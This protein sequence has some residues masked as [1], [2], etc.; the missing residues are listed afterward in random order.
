MQLV[1]LRAHA[2]GPPGAPFE[3]GNL[4]VSGD[5][6]TLVLGDNGVGKSTLIR[7]SQLVLGRSRQI[8]RIA[9]L[10]GLNRVGQVCTEWLDPGTGKRV[11]LGIALEKSGDE[12]RS[13]RY[14]IELLEGADVDEVAYLEASSL[15][16][17]RDQIVS[18]HP[19]ATWMQNS[20]S[21]HAEI[22]RWG[23]GRDS[24]LGLTGRDDPESPRQFGAEWI[25]GSSDLV[26]QIIRAVISPE[27]L[28]H[29]PVTELA[30]RSFDLLRMLQNRSMIETERHGR[31]RLLEFR[32]TR[33][34]RELIEQAA[35]DTPTQDR[36]S[37]THQRGR[38]VLEVIMRAVNGR[39]TARVFDTRQGSYRSLE[40]F[41]AQASS[42][43]R[44]FVFALLQF[45]VS[46][47]SADGP[48]RAVLFDHQSFF[49]PD[50]T[51]A[52][53]AIRK[54]GAS[55]VSFRAAAVFSPSP[56]FGSV[57]TLAR[58]PSAHA[59][60][61]TIIGSS[62]SLRDATPTSHNGEA[63]DT[64]IP[65]GDLFK[66]V[67]E[68]DL[69]GPDDIVMA[70]LRLAGT[71]GNAA[72]VGEAK[73]TGWITHTR[74]ALRAR[75]QL[76]AGELMYYVRYL[77]GDQLLGNHVPRGQMIIIRPGELTDVRVRKPD[78]DTL[79]AIR[80][81]SNA[82]TTFTT[83]RNEA[84]RAVDSYF[85][86]DNP[87]QSKADL[88]TAGRLTRQRR[89]AA[90]ALDVPGSKFRTTMPFPIAR[91]WRNVEA[92]R[93]DQ[94]GYSEVLECA[95]L[96]VTYCAAVGLAAALNQ[97]STFPGLSNFAGKIRQGN[98]LTFGVWSRLLEDLAGH[99]RSA[100][101]PPLSP[102]RH[103]VEFPSTAIAA[104]GEL[105]SR[106]NDIS[107]QRRPGPHEVGTHFNDA[108]RSLL[109]L[110]DCFYWLT[111]YPL[112]IVEGE[113]WDSLADETEVS[114]RELVGDHSVVELKS[115]RTR[116]RL[117]VGSPYIADPYDRYLLLRPI[118]HS[119]I[120]GQCGQL[121]VF[122]IEKWRNVQGS[123]DYRALDHGHVC[124][125]PAASSLRAIGLIPPT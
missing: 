73:L 82:A 66:V 52:L 101:L 108:R 58:V 77:G 59:S 14:A 91:R 70:T 84:H 114:F 38:A 35:A 109:H 24:V 74:I 62:I 12:V 69:H 63:D 19:G 64:T 23:L 13:T 76:D 36:S 90:H 7:L 11:L 45:F 41:Q 18:G 48:V 79:R 123:A 115:G 27:E 71:S 121:T 102:L 10:L 65:L 43:E 92:S 54:L 49:R 4:P 57:H 50:D 61:Q 37:D 94:V 117:E 81:L 8:R 1:S 103:F 67:Q 60:F 15:H 16:A 89:D 21:W 46:G 83:W 51:P 44:D 105:K 30:S 95:E 17:A 104:V 112:R 28:N 31:R 107:H 20:A 42:G 86:Q 72:T 34:S 118:L 75:R 87:S 111:D 33:P 22:A 99:A 29:L 40:T 110:M 5:S 98:P 120:C 97:T 9:P 6:A 56:E 39:L 55:V 106:R 113:R 96:V 68:T 32:F 119:G 3:R 85:D 78:R 88:V 124:E 93:P 2:I 80:D 100:S 125:V 25:K 26:E 53:A 122:I 47:L 116:Q